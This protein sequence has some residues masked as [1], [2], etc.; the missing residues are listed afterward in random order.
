MNVAE[1]VKTIIAEQLGVEAEEGPS[2]AVELAGGA[3]VV[4]Q[5]VPDEKS[6]AQGA[7]GITGR[8]LYPDLVKG[9]S[10]ESSCHHIAP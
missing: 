9:P 3:R 2:L 1:K 4:E 8:R 5:L 7:A 10:G 6:R